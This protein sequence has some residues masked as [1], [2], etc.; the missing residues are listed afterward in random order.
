MKK[1]QWFA[2][3][4]DTPYYHTLYKHR[5]D[6]EAQHFLDNLL[7]KLKPKKNAR[8][9]DLACGKGRHSI[10]LAQKGYKVIGVDLSPKSIRIAKKYKARNLEFHVHDMRKV[11]KAKQFDLILNLFTSFGYFENDDDHLLTLKNITIQ[12]RKDGIF[13]MDFM[14]VHKVIANL[15]PREQKVVDGIRF[16]ITRKVKDGHIIKRIS[17]TDKGKKFVF[18]EKV[19]AFTKNELKKLFAQAALNITAI[20]GNYDLKAFRKNSSDRLILVAERRNYELK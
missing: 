9:L 16:Y 5:N 8:L 11:F 1:K 2:S 7:H 20:Y 4:F 19:R 13:V 3:W 12:L 15:K 18:Q 14:N 17:F 10:Y 6:E